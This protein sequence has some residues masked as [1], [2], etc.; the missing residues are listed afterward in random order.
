MLAAGGRRGAVPGTT[1]VGVGSRCTRRTD[2]GRTI[3]ENVS[4][5][6]LSGGGGAIKIAG[7]MSHRAV[8]N[9]LL[10][11]AFFQGVQ[12]PSTGRPLQS[13]F[14][15]SRSIFE[16]LQKGLRSTNTLNGR[17]FFTPKS[18]TWGNGPAVSLFQRCSISTFDGFPRWQP[19]AGP[20][21]AVFESGGAGLRPEGSRPPGFQIVH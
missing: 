16:G 1:G 18:H 3:T 20:P 2:T 7:A 10:Y 15:W 14:G 11:G 8:Q 4:R 12:V 13:S 17:A 9:L 5:R 21:H 19:G 6:R